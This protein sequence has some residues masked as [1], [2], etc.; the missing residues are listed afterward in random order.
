LLIDVAVARLDHQVG[1]VDTNSDLP[2]L[3]RL[4]CGLRVIA[5]AVLASQLFGDLYER[6]RDAL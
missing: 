1:L 2:S 4:P 5:E 3:A 6:L